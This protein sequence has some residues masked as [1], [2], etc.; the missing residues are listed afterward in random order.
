MDVGIAATTTGARI[1]GVMKGACDGGL[2]VPHSV[3]RFPGYTRA[4][5]EEVVN[6]RGKATGE[7]EK[8]DAGFEAAVLRE[9]I[10]GNHVNKYMNSLKKDDPSKFKRQ[11]SLW[12]KCLAEN[13]VKNTEELYKSV[14]KKILADCDRKKSA[15]N[16]KPVHKKTKETG[17]AVVYS[18]SKKSSWLRHRKMT[19]T[20]RKAAVAT[21]F[22]ALMS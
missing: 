5:V 11:F 15:S 21:K 16:A 3:K 19:G 13:K 20:E 9:Y 7:V 2:N 17:N 14:H 12:E 22:A 4:K 1:F 18:N 10:F 6:K 8:T